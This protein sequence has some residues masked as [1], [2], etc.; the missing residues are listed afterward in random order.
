MKILK[1]QVVCLHTK[2]QFG[3]SKIMLVLGDTPQNPPKT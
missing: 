1:G 3:F 2:F